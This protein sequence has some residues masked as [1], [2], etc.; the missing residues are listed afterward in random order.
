M[1]RLYGF[2]YGV[3]FLLGYHRVFVDSQYPAYLTNAGTVQGKFCYLFFYALFSRIIEIIQLKTF[4]AR[5]APPALTPV[6]SVTVLLYIN[7]TTGGTT[8]SLRMFHLFFCKDKFFQRI[9]NHDGIF[10][11]CLMRKPTELLRFQML[12]L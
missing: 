1:S 8:Y 5:V 3:F 11:P 4:A 6:F 7:G 10:R 2:R 12:F 9:L